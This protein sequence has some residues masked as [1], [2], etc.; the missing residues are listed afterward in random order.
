M[1][2]QKFLAFF[3]TKFGHWVTKCGNFYCYAETGNVYVLGGFSGKQRLN[4]VERYNIKED[5][6]S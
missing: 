4:T 3:D 5:R 6:W 1:V 2:T